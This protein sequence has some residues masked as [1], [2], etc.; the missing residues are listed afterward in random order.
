LAQID[1]GQCNETELSSIAGIDDC[2]QD[3]NASWAEGVAWFNKTKNE[4]DDLNDIVQWIAKY[5]QEQEVHQ[6]KSRPARSAAERAACVA[7]DFLCAGSVTS[8]TAAPTVDDDETASPT[9]PTAAPILEDDILNMSST[10]LGFA[11]IGLTSLA[12]LVLCAF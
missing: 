10:A 2:S 9:P 12:A 11:H 3:E 8:P 4:G 6:R 7:C 5:R 1:A